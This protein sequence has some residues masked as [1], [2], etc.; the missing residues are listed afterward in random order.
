MPNEAEPLR[1]AGAC[2]C[3]NVQWRSSAS[4]GLQFNCYCVDCRKSTG[5][6]C[7][8]IML[9][10]ADD[11]EL[12]GEITY[13]HSV[14]GSGNVIRRGFC[15]HCGAQVVA[16]VELIPGMLSIR[17]GTLADITQFEPKAN[18]F[19]SHAPA[20]SPPTPGLPSFARLPN[21]G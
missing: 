5:A 4:P 16:H 17:A 1:Y 11:V 15:S 18:I 10:K 12:H 20:W 19:V 7:L 13:F 9:F 6:A 8:P 14:G 3:G 2:L 21:S